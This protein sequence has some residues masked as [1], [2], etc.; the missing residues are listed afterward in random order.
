MMPSPW[1]LI[2]NSP[3]RINDHNIFH[4]AWLDGALS[5]VVDRE[6]SAQDKCL[7]ILD[8]ILMSNI[9]LAKRSDQPQHTMAWQLLAIMA[10]KEGGEM[11]RYAIEVI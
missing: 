9:C 11:R 6:Q 8:D 4:R 3:P 10:S 5:L 7:D 2:S 1:Q